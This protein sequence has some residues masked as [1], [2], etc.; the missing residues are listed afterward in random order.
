M[1]VGSGT[2]QVWVVVIEYAMVTGPVPLPLSMLFTS[3]CGTVMAAQPTCCVGVL[4]RLRWRAVERTEPSTQW[5]QP[6]RAR[7]PEE[8]RVC[9]ATGARST[10]H[11]NS[12]ID[13]NIRPAQLSLFYSILHSECIRSNESTQWRCTR[14]KTQTMLHSLKKA[15]WTDERRQQVVSLYSII[16]SPLSP[17]TMVVSASGATSKW[18]V[19]VAAA[20]RHALK[21]CVDWCVPV[22]RDPTGKCVHKSFR[23]LFETEPM[24]GMHPP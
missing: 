14:N 19:R 5:F 24:M 23:D 12:S 7:F 9:A 21:P 8:R 16:T 2:V 13:G 17:S 15:V 6:F 22:H 18:S 20:C 3:T 11:T 1:R 4:Y 10:N